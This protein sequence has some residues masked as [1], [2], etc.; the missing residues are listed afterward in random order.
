MSAFSLGP[1]TLDCFGPYIFLSF[2]SS[3]APKKIDAK[4]LFI[5][6]RVEKT[7]WRIDGWHN[8][9]FYNIYAYVIITVIINLCPLYTC[10]YY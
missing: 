1:V 5:Y 4:Y 6:F 7:Q 10:Y 8:M 3:A 2:S 9:V